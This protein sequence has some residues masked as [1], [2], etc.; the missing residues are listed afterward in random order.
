MFLVFGIFLELLV[1]NYMVSYLTQTETS[2]K[3][4][5]KFKDQHEDIL[6]AI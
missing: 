3:R 5:L 2:V 4:G 1:I 6:S